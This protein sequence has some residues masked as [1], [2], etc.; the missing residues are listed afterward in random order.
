MLTCNFC[1]QEREFRQFYG[2][3][4]RAHGIGDVNC[5]PICGW[6]LFAHLSKYYPGPPAYRDMVSAWGVARSGARNE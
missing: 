5:V 6:C 2:Y 4:D 1:H 3:V